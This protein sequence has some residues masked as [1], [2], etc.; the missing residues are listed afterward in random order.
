V[1]GSGDVVEKVEEAAGDMFAVG[2]LAIQRKLASAAASAATASAASVEA[3]A[4]ETI[5]HA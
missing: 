5:S 4:D 2:D 1:L 3:K